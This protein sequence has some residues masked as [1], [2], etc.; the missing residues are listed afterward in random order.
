VVSLAGNR[1]TLL[2]GEIALLEEIAL[3]AGT[4]LNELDREAERTESIHLESRLSQQLVQAELR[5]LRAQI[6]PHFLFNSLNT[7]AALIPS[8]PE[9]AETMTVRLARI[10]RHVLL[11]ADRPFSSIDEEMYFLRTYL[12]IE[13]VRFGERLQVEFEVD[14]SIGH[15]AIPSLI[16]QPLV[17]N[18]IRHGVAPKV[19]K[20]R[21]LVQAKRQGEQ[22]LLSV[23]DDGIGLLQKQDKVEFPGGGGRVAEYPGASANHVWFH[24]QAF[25]RQYPERWQPGHA[26]NFQLGNKA[27]QI[28][29][30]LADDEPAA[31][32]RLRR[33]LDR[34]PQ[35]TVIG[36][37]TN[38][39]EA[40]EAI[41]RLRP[42]LLFLDIQMPGLSGFEVLK[43]L[44][45]DTPRP[46]TIFVTG[47]HEHALEAFRARA[48]AYLLKPI[49]EDHLGE[50]I[51]RAGRLLGS[52]PSREKEEENV[53]RLLGDELPAMEQIVARKANRV[54]LLDP[55]EA[56]VFYMDGGIV[57]VRVGERY[58]LGQLSTGRVGAGAWVKRVLPRPA[59]CSRQSEAGQG[60]PL[61]FA[62]QLV[63]VMSDE[64]GTEVEVSERQGRAL[65]SRFP[66]L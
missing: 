58:L 19:G 59:L 20:S 2:S 6:N 31:R 5:A 50:M 24:R 64:K 53:N 57:R 65:R 18:A 45:K 63:L 47:F 66:G 9:K 46:L 54:F 62:E 40:V 15:A 14:T 35:L 11:H 12:D 42:E 33:L 56:L 49:E 8:E 43:G 28:R 61:G 23:E 13:Q 34:H 27:M 36:E 3:Y 44:S 52:L 30:F 10:F 4:R 7:I 21:I 48:I 32:V 16:L 60:D 26:L 41:E 25:A 55:A 38:G 17:E 1:R 22:I 51:D 29:T 39:I 37:A